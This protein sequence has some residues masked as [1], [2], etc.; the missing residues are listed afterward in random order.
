MS[1]FIHLTDLCFRRNRGLRSFTQSL[2]KL[3]A[4]DGPRLP[5]FQVVITAVERFTRL[6]EFGNLS[7]Q[8]VYKQLVGRTPGPDD[9]LANL[10]L[11]IGCGSYF[12]GFRSR[13]GSK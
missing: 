4:D 8:R 5:A 3:F 6:Q 1:F 12:H 11:E 9:Q 13:K 2:E 10:G 7:G